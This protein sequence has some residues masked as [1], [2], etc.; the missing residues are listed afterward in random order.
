M[1]RYSGL[2]RF[3]RATYSGKHNLG[4]IGSAYFINPREVRTCD[5]SAFNEA[6]VRDCNSVLYLYFTSLGSSGWI[7][8]SQVRTIKFSKVGVSY[9][10]SVA[11]SPW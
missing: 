8:F 9:S 10:S 4:A 5:I 7:S 6:R 1:V 11:N 3:A 2:K